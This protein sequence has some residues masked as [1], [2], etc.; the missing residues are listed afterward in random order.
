MVTVTRRF[1]AFQQHT[2]W[3]RTLSICYFS[4]KVS[5]KIMKGVQTPGNLVKE[6]KTL[7][8]AWMSEQLSINAAYLDPRP[9]K[10]ANSRLPS[11]VPAQR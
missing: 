8:Y 11:E 3:V 2:V 10:Y 7:S 4:R 9:T 6:V 1:L 5:A